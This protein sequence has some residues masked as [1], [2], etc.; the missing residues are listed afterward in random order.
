MIKGRLTSQKFA[1]DAQKAA[2]E[3]SPKFLY[4]QLIGINTKMVIIG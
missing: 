3:L 2:K 1:S 4:H